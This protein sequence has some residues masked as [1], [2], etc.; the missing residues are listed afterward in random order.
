MR[1]IL[2][3]ERL[4]NYW[5]N[6]LAKVSIYRMTFIEVELLKNDLNF[7]KNE[8]QPSCYNQLNFLKVALNLAVPSI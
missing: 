7:L 5:L 4:L 2:C 8:F 3:K 1:F 6:S